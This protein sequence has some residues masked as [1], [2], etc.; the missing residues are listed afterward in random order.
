MC[1][2]AKVPLRV[3]REILNATLEEKKDLISMIF[4]MLGKDGQNI[5]SVSRRRKIIK[6]RNQQNRKKK[7]RKNEKAK[8][9]P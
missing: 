5:S 7:N 4:K 2:A 8:T 6:S 9:I 1:D 3:I